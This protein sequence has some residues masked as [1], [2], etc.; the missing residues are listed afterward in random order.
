MKTVTDIRVVQFVEARLATTFIPPYTAMGVE[1]DGEVAGGIVFNIFEG[2]DCHMTVA[3]DR[4]P[5]PKGFLGEVGIYLFDQLKRERVTVM[6]EQ[7][8]VVSIAKRLGGAV[9]GVLRSHYG[10]GRDATIVGILKSDWKYR[11][12]RA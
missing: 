3:S 1:I 4:R 12:H 11:R 6:T 2:A 8:K 10:P 9:E 7:P 5:W